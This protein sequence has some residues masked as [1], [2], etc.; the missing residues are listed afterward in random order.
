M[1]AKVSKCNVVICTDYVNR[2][3][4]KVKEILERVSRI[5]T[6]SYIR[7]QQEGAL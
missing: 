4:D 6:G 7:M 1:G 2:D 5:V 3:P